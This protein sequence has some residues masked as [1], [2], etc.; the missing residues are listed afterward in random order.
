MPH[1]VKCRNK[2]ITCPGYGPRLRWA[3][4]VAVRGRFRGLKVPNLPSVSQS[5]SQ[6]TGGSDNGDREQK[7]K[8]STANEL[9]AYYN[10]EIAPTNVWVHSQKNEYYRLVTP[11]A[12]TQPILR[13]AMIGIAAAH[14]PQSA[15]RT[16]ISRWACQEALLLVTDRVRQLVLSAETAGEPDEA[17]LAATL[18]LSNHSLLRSE[19]S[20]ALFH[21]Q[22]ARVLT[23]TV[24]RATNGELFTFLKNQVAGLDVLACTTIFDVNYLRGAVLPELGPVPVVFGV[25]LRI[26]HRVTLCSID[27]SPSLSFPDLEDDFE[28]A[29]GE[30]LLAAARLVEHSSGSYRRDIIRLI[31]SFHHAGLIY[32][33][34]RTST[35]GGEPEWHVTKLFR[36]LEQF[37]DIKECIGNLSWPLLISGICSSNSTARQTIVRSLCNRLSTASPFKYYANIL[38]FLEELWNSEHQD[39]AITAREWEDKSIPILAV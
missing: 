24:H 29:R 10:S 38:T 25:F 19:I 34:R 27:P 31:H 2:N 22:A 3:N 23:K 35:I 7:I 16:A 14:Q 37:E 18:V 15:E 5:Q 39:W 30:S 21:L 8:D 36:L 28:L 13:L 1:C 17:V 32:A 11:L 26:L 9:L 12:V 20:L 6:F 4:A 33:S